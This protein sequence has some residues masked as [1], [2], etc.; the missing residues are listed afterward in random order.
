MSHFKKIV[1]GALALAVSMAAFATSA[2]ENQCT[3]YEYSNYGGKSFSLGRNGVLA[4]GNNVEVQFESERRDYGD[5]QKKVDPF[6]AGK[7]SSISTSSN[8]VAELNFGG[9]NLNH[10]TGKRPEISGDNNKIQYVGC[11]CD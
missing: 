6:W 2:Q 3:F 11:T 9:K 5:Y 10:V 7:I 1:T 8:C 4:V